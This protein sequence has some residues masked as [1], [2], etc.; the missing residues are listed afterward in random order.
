M[1]L[2]GAALAKWLGVDLTCAQEVYQPQQGSRVV[3][4]YSLISDKQLGTY[5]DSEP[6]YQIADLSHVP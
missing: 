3:I 2:D 5:T 1:V 4:E 6:N